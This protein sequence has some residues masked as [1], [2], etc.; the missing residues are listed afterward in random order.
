V[1]GP[2]KGGGGGCRSPCSASG[3]ICVEIEGSE[4]SVCVWFRTMLGILIESWE[5]SLG[6]SFG[7]QPSYGH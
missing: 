6:G 2:K 4:W 7:G 1:A 5:L 3:K